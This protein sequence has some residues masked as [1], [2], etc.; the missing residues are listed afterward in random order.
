MTLWR[1]QRVDASQCIQIG[2]LVVNTALKTV[3]VREKEIPLTYRE[4]QL[5]TFLVTHQR[6]TFAR[7]TVLAHVWGYDFEGDARVVD[8]YI[9][10]VRAK[11]PSP[12]D[13]MLETVWGMGY[14]FAPG[15]LEIC[16]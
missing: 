15:R 10:R 13:A 5:L 1:F 7:E 11:L 6:S 14:R 12:Y 4:F 3:K 9:K 8:T 2:E 16:H